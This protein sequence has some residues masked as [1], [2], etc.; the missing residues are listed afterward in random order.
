MDLENT[1][2]VLDWIKNKEIKI[3]RKNT[4]VVSP[5][6]INLLLASHSDVIRLEDKIEFIKRVYAELKKDKGKD[7]FEKAVNLG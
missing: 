2:L 5:F 4:K 3:E 7:N 1:G 6:A